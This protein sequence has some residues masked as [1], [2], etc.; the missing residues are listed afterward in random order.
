M[1]SS[2]DYC[3]ILPWLLCDLRGNDFEFTSCP[4]AT[5]CVLSGPKQPKCALPSPSTTAA[6]AL[7]PSGECGVGTALDNG[8]CNIDC[9]PARRLTEALKLEAPAEEAG[10]QIQP[11]GER[12]LVRALLNEDPELAARIRASGD[13]DDDLLDKLTRFNQLFGQ[14]ALA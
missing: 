8:Q 4:P 10:P 1:P 5:A 11:S 6:P 7:P 14:P 2:L 9:G 13:V 12:E 3:T